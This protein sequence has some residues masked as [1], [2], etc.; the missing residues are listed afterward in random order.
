MVQIGGKDQH[1]AQKAQE[2][3]EQRALLAALGGIGHHGGGKAGLEGDDGAGDL[4][5]H[6]GDARDRPQHQAD[7]QLVKD[8]ADDLHHVL[9]HGGKARR[10]Q[11]INHEREGQREAEAH[12]GGDQ[13]L[14]QGRHQHEDGAD[15]REQQDIDEGRVGEPVEADRH[16]Q[17]PTMIM[18]TMRAM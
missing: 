8:Q 13:I 6:D 15:T 14:A 11:R 16:A 2:A 3:A 1:H 9:G 10:Q 17:P 18:S 12:A 5:G 7:G 4:G